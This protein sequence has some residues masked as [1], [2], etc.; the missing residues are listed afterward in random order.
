[1]KFGFRK[2]A[3]PKGG[4]VTPRKYEQIIERRQTAK[5]LLRGVEKDITVATT[6]GA[7]AIPSGNKAVLGGFGFFFGK[8][9]SRMAAE[10]GH[11]ISLKTLAE[12][13]GRPKLAEKILRGSTLGILDPAFARLIRAWGENGPRM[14]AKERVNFVKDNQ[15]KTLG[16]MDP[17]AEAR[18]R[19]QIQKWKS[20]NF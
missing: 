6:V 20:G 3:Q 4:L 10:K 17:A 5:S 13:S 1:M 16:Q 19:K 14:N 8:T 7:M 2:R 9:L 18:Y 15:R 12:I 11:K